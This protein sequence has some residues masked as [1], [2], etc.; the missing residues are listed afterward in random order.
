MAMRRLYRD[1]YLHD[2]IAG[3]AVDLQAQLPF[4]D[5]TLSSLPD[6]NMLRAFAS[7]LEAMHIKTLLPE[8]ATEYQV[9]GAFIGNINFNNELKRVTSVMPQN[10]DSCKI[11][12]LPIYGRDPIIDV[13]IPD[14]QKKL[15]ESPDPRIREAFSKY[16]DDMKQM[17]KAGKFPLDPKFTLYLA[18]RTFATTTKGMSYY[19][20]IIPIWLWE[21]A[22]LRGT[23]DLSYRRQK[24]ILHL[25][26]GDDEWEPDNDQL[27]QLV[28]MFISADVDPTGAVIATRPGV[29]TSEIRCLAGD[30]LIHTHKGLKRIDELAYYD[31]AAGPGSA[32][33]SILVKN[34]CGKYSQVNQWHYQGYNPTVTVQTSNGPVITCTETHKIL[35]LDAQAGLALT[36]A[37]DMLGKYVLFD[38]KGAESG[39]VVQSFAHLKAS[40]LQD[41]TSGV[42]LPDSMNPALAY[43]LGLIISGGS[44][45]R[46]NIQIV[47]IDHEITDEVV[48]ILKDVFNYTPHL[49][50]IPAPYGLLVHS[51]HN[52]KIANTT[53]TIENRAIVQFFQCIGIEP[54]EFYDGVVSL[55]EHLPWSILQSTHARKRSFIAACIDIAGY[56]MDLNTDSGPAV[57]IG[58]TNNSYPI[59]NKLKILLADLGI[60]TILPSKGSRLYVASNDVNRLY[61]GLRPF[62]IKKSNKPYAYVNRHP[63]SL[64]GIPADVFLPLLEARTIPT[65]HVKPPRFEG[66]SV[67]AMEID[68]N[69]K[70]FIQDNGTI[71]NSDKSLLELFPGEIENK[72][73][74]YYDKFDCGEYKEQLEFIKTVSCKLYINLM[75]LFKQK[76]RFETVTAIKPAGKRHTYDISVAED[77]P[78]FLANGILVK[79]SGSD[80]WRYDEIYDFACFTGSTLVPTEQGLL[81]LDEIGNAKGESEQ[82]I[83]ITVSGDL[84]PATANKFWRKG[85]RSVARLELENGAQN[86]ITPSHKF[87]VFEPKRNRL[88]WRRTAHLNKGDLLCFDT[89]KLVR[90]IPL[91]L[92]LSA[93]STYQTATPIIRPTEMTP[94]LAF[95]LGLLVSEGDFNGDSVRFTNADKKLLNLYQEK[96]QSV[97]GLSTQISTTKLA[98][99]TWNIKGRTG[100]SK[101]TTYV[102]RTH[103]RS[104]CSWLLELG[105]TNEGKNGKR[106]CLSKILPW[107]IRQAD[108][109]SQLAYIGAYIEG[110]GSISRNHGVVTI[111]SGCPEN[112]RQ[113][114]SMIATHGCYSVVSGNKLTMNPTDSHGFLESLKPFM[115]TKKLRSVVFIQ[116][117]KRGVPTAGLRNFIKSRMIRYHYRDIRFITDNDEEIQVPHWGQIS[118][119]ILNAAILPVSAFN[120]GKYDEFLNIL[121]QISPTEA[122]YT[123]RLFK[124]QYTFVKVK[125]VTDLKKKVSVYDL[126]ISEDHHPA[127]VA[128]GVVAHN[129]GAKMRALGIS[130]GFLS[131][132]STYSNMETS[133]SVFLE[134]IRAFRE[135]ITS[136]VFYQKLFPLIAMENDFI[137]KDKPFETKGSYNGRV[138]DGRIKS[139][140]DK[141]GRMQYTA[142]IG[143]SNLITLGNDDNDVDLTKLYMPKI[144]WHKA[145]KPEADTAYISMLT[146]LQQS[147]GL[148]IPLRI[149]AA[150]GGLPITDIMQ[151]LDEDV[152]LRNLV[153][154]YKKKLPKAPEEEANQ[155]FS[156]AALRTQK[157]N[158]SFDNV[159]MRDADTRKTLSRKGRAVIEERANK[160]AAPVL[161]NLAKRHNVEEL[162]AREARKRIYH[163]MTKRSIFGHLDNTGA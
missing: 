134:Q 123:R 132:E 76:Y 137:I 125:K 65:C 28:N 90:T 1:M 127:F 162:G 113:M 23:I 96:M 80:F 154:K 18:R 30:T 88:V 31:T 43:L 131:G 52:P 44:L 11:T 73:P 25:I 7:S 46:D 6:Q 50:S 108:E 19:R 78:I 26:A 61:T 70:V 143:S 62:L 146:E 51:P 81:R 124:S 97:F 111:A 36:K 118:N 139:Y 33:I 98:G 17:I 101:V 116:N 138:N 41:D 102:A 37:E 35:S 45:V 14:T 117:R 72:T 109:Q 69:T 149:W 135:F 67:T 155:L 84:G 79:N 75:N 27:N 40:I 120:S 42:T 153:D 157:R 86:I 115:P 10:A 104:L 8:A 5:F 140:R 63:V 32:E 57:T 48:A 49:Q 59:L 20:R 129:S 24:S 21:K 136:K 150:A 148:P 34:I 163:F 89:K 130:D 2:P 99:D 152:K 16:G 83:D 112:L 55:H 9:D 160:K 151:S 47:A 105:L 110:D 85:E 77:A 64:L 95:I 29:Q 82:D 74:L 13:I 145:L 71:Y 128:N 66:N 103:S 122:K 147:S 133:L 156:G 53:I 68:F 58:I 141:K 38:T 119:N 92:D 107:S 22:L 12:E 106:A 142:V 159:E 91:E 3:S 126:S 114:Q 158:R 161:A 93:P 121:E 100:T 60:E 144:H 94:D 4:S 87:L 56:V 15:F 54:G 39:E